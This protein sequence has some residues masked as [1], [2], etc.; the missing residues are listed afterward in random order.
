MGAVGSIVLIAISLLMI[1]WEVAY[2]F[3]EMYELIRLLIFVLIGNYVGQTVSKVTR[4]RGGQF[5]GRIAIFSYLLGLFFIPIF[6][7]A[8]VILLLIMLFI[9]DFSLAVATVRDIYTIASSE[10][11]VNGILGTLGGGLL[12]YQRSR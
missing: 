6:L 5:V 9:L 12:A 11:G 3:P 2:T 4:Q 8:L 1:D 7:V 10:F